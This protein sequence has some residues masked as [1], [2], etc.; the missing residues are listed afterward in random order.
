MKIR[1]NGKVLG[2]IIYMLIIDVKKDGLKEVSG[3]RISENESASFWLSA[4]TDIDN[5]CE[6]IR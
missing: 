5:Q 3:I 1:Q 6:K 2:I 4:L